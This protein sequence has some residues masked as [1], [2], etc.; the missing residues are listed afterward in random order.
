MPQRCRDA[1][2]TEMKESNERA[3]QKK[4]GEQVGVPQ[5]LC[6]SFLVVEMEKD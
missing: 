2:S 1:I 4:N 5:K 3:G 6:I